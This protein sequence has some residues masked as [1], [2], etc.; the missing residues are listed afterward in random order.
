M[1]QAAVFRPPTAHGP[2]GY[3]LPVPG[4]RPIRVELTANSIG[5]ISKNDQLLLRSRRTIECAEEIADQ[6][7][8]H[9]LVLEADALRK[10]A[11][12]WRW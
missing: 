6:L 4:D 12:K 7:A 2:A 11:Q 1:E 3:R 10:E 9:R 5:V 8:A